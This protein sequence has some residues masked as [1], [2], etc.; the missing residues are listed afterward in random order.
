MAVD[1]MGHRHRIEVFT[2]VLAGQTEGPQTLVTEDGESVARISKGLYRIV[3]G[4]IELI[5]N[6]MAAP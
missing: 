1:R 4:G 5:S 3:Q 6:D 2:E